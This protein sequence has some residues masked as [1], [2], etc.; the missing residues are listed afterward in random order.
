[1][2]WI[3]GLLLG[4]AVIFGVVAVILAYVLWTLYCW[5]EHD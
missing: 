4:G 3:D 5:M 2:N 1:M